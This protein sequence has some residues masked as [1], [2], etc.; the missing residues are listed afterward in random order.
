MKTLN[1]NIDHVATIREARG[2]KEPDPVA[3]AILAEL[4]GASGIVCHLREDRRHINDR[5]VKILREV[6]QSK[7]DLEMAAHEEIINIALNLKPDLVTIVPEGRM[8]L[9]TEGGLDVAGNPDKFESLVERMHGNGIEVSFFVEPDK[10]QI[11]AS[12]LAGADMVELHTGNYANAKG[13]LF[14]DELEKIKIASFF[15]NETRLKIAAGHGINYLNIKPLCLIPEIGEFSIGH[16][17]ISRAI[18]V[19]IERA[20]REM[21]EVINTSTL[22]RSLNR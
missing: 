12:L 13:E 6:V 17:I 19:G 10:K 7:L 16:S 2:G 20:T 11:E 9:T 15:A 1:V 18:H 4:A 22:H 5:D 8:E 14:N 21:I 3:T